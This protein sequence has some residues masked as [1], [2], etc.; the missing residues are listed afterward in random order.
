M[1]N[2]VPKYAQV[3]TVRS[4]MLIS[5][6]TYRLKIF[7]ILIMDILFA[8]MYFY[9]DYYYRNKGKEG[10]SIFE[11]TKA[12]LESFLSVDGF[13]SIAFLLLIFFVLFIVIPIL[14]F[15]IL[16]YFLPWFLKK[17]KKG[18]GILNPFNHIN[19]WKSNPNLKEYE[20]K[21]RANKKIETYKKLKYTPF[22]W[23]KETN[24]GI[25][26]T[27]YVAF[28]HWMFHVYFISYGILNDFIALK[29]EQFTYKVFLGIYAVMIFMFMY[30]SKEPRRSEKQTEK[31]LKPALKYY[32]E[33]SEFATASPEARRQFEE[34]FK[35]KYRKNEKYYKGH[36][37]SGVYNNP[38]YAYAVIIDIED[39]VTS[40]K[41]SVKFRTTKDFQKW[42]LVSGV[43]VSTK[44]GRFEG[45]RK[46]WYEE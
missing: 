12:G 44:H 26:T 2:E 33:A 3:D 1:S 20:R 36:F 32:Y 9:Y 23:F 42:D 30:L 4:Y 37:K 8:Y 6:K 28:V 27:R 10:A 41:N 25:I 35:I 46:K 29:D 38:E 24:L 43:E 39:V 22:L 40:A 34:Q 14:F 13:A 18:I 31:L 19:R 16:F 45:R 7:I 15:M 11:V 5:E 21:Q 17:L